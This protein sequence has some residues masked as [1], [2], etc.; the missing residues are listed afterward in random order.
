VTANFFMAGFLAIL[1][2][3]KWT[4]LTPLSCSLNATDAVY[5]AATQV[6]KHGIFSY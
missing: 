4:L 6:R 1:V 3:L 2:E 5:A